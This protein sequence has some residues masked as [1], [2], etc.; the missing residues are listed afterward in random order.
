MALYRES[1]IFRLETDVP[2]MFWTGQGDL[3][4][5]ADAVLLVDEIALG[6][7]HLINVPDVEQ[8]INGLSQQIE[9]QLSG[10]ADE[11]LALAMEESAQVPGAAAYIGRVSFDED[12]QQNGP[13]E[14]EWTGEGVSLK[15]SSEDTDGGHVRQLT[16]KVA[17]GDT[18]RSRSPYAFFT[19]AD[20]R[21]DYPDDIIFANVGSINNGISRRW[22]AGA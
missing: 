5:P 20:Q 19:D 15:V 2:A 17:A 18:T 13:V 22:G 10:I 3:L 14:W 21:R 4:L 6:G 7:A 9:I 11:T 16:L 1:F 12:W 8:L